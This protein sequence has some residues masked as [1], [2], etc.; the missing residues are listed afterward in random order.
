MVSSFHPHFVSKSCPLPSHNHYLHTSTYLIWLISIRKFV[1]DSIYL[2]F[3]TCFLYLL[4]FQACQAVLHWHVPISAFLYGSVWLGISWKFDSIRLDIRQINL[5][6]LYCISNV[7]LIHTFPIFPNSLSEIEKSIE[8]L[9]VQN[10][11]TI[12]FSHPH[13]KA[14]AQGSASRGSNIEESGL[15]GNQ[16]R[17]RRKSCRSLL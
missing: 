2:S 15:W 14:L 12:I 7:I 17:K 6:T 4:L 11:G 3:D 5:L 8:D 13:Q 9:N 16:E 1:L 10:W